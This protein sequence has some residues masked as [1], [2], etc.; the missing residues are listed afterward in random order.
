[1][2]DAI[3][4]PGGAFG[5]GAGML[6]YVAEAVE[7]RGARVHRHWWSSDPEDAAEPG[8]E[9][10]VT[11][12]VAPLVDSVGGRPLLIGK[13]LG[14]NGAALAAERGLPAVWL[15]PVLTLPW[16]AAALAA[17]PAPFLLV[18]GTADR[19]WDSAAAARLT[20]H[21]F[22]VEGADHGMFV[23]GPV[24]DSL[25]VLTRMI[26]AVEGFLDDID[27]PA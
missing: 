10:W 22:E 4:I 8:V 27:W 19:W 2:A 16:V 26:A 7:R 3:V 1:M 24:A 17:S 9:G 18:G 12:E 15:T 13:S 5:P 21:L 20:P 6:M 25:D 14:T 11:S 23:P